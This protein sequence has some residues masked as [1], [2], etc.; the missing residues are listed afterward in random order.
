M[1]SQSRFRFV[2][3]NDTINVAG[4]YA[5]AHPT[6]GS[7]TATSKEPTATPGSKVTTNGPAQTST[8]GANAAFGRMEDM[9]LWI[10]VGGGMVAFAANQF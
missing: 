8:S 10:V 6:A 7:A 5:S 3:L 1:G 9:D 4:C 2:S